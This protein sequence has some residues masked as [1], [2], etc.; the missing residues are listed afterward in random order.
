M[1]TLIKI[2]LPMA[3]LGLLGGCGSQTKSHSASS[4]SSAKTENK[5]A[6]NSSASQS[7]SE[8]AASESTSSSEKTSGKTGEKV[9][10]EQQNKTSTTQ[11]HPAVTQQSVANRIA[12]SLSNQYAPQDLTFQFSQSGSGTYVVQVRENH[13]SAN[14]RAQGA[15]PSTSPTIAWYKTNANGQLLKS[16][17]G[18]VT[19]VVVGNAY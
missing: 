10:S 18:G 16:V 12:Q 6:N 1:K 14:M 4:E 3:V 7:S 5:V 17:D 8:Q 13:Q 11:T 2:V 9:T 15:D 19:Y